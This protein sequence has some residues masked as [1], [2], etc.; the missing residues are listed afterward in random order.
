MLIWLAATAGAWA[1]SPPPPKDVWTGKGQGRL[2]GYG[3]QSNTKAANA[4]VDMAYIDDQWTHTFHFGALYGENDGIISAN[5]WDV[6][7]QS[8]YNL[9]TDLYTYGA[10]RYLHDRLN[11][12]QYQASR[13]I[14]LRYAF[15][16]TDATKL[17]AQI[18]VGYR[19]GRPEELGKCRRGGQYPDTGTGNQ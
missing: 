9:T 15:I 2:Y 8:N 16:K 13:A 1:D 4:A 7:W 17:S 14:G 6:G 3:G 10:L 11:G 5:R 12:F 19:N 18:G